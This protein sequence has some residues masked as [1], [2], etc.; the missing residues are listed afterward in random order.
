[1]SRPWPSG[2]QHMLILGLA[3][4][5]WW[6]FGALYRQRPALAALNAA[7][8]LLLAMLS[9]LLPREPHDPGSQS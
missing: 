8:G 1:M 7:M 5:N 2:W 9:S 3:L 4:L 6:E